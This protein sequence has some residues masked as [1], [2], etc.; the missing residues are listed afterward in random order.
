[1]SGE[2][3]IELRSLE[4]EVLTQAVRAAADALNRAEVALEPEAA[5]EKVVQ[6]Y[7]AARRK[8]RDGDERPSPTA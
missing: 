5:A 7:F 3:T 6:A 8:L 4:G 2:Q 1:M